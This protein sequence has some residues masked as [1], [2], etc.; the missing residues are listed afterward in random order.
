MMDYSARLDALQKRVEDAKSA[1]QSAVTESRDQLRQ[2][3]GQAQVDMN[4]AVK[5]AQQRAGEATDSARS[6]WAQMKADAAAKMDDL[7]AKIDKRNAQQDA[8]IAVNDADWAEEDAADAIDYA[9]WAVDNARLAMLDAI[10]ARL[11]ADDLAKV[12]GS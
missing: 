8:N 2:R 3:I 1:A 9:A 4:L 12:A 6:K 5:D 10:D 7:K 11:Y